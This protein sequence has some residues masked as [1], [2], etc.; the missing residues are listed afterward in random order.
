MC[1]AFVVRIHGDTDTTYICL[2]YAHARAPLQ[3]QVLRFR[4]TQTKKE[5]KPNQ[6]NTDTAALVRA[7]L[8]RISN[9][10]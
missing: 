10:W 9:A 4:L 8:S 6:T 2:I 5:E 1:V 7:R 3:K